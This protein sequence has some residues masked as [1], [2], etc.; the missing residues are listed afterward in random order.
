MK[1]Y[2]RVL[3]IEDKVVVKGDV[4]VYIR[5]LRALRT[6]PGKLH[7]PQDSLELVRSTVAI[8]AFL[9]VSLGN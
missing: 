7:L 1:L 4:R 2:P 5:I 8:V 6:R 9:Y 3:F